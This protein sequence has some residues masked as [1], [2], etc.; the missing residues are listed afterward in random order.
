[1]RPPRRGR[2]TGRGRGEA[3]RGLYEKIYIPGRKNPL[4][5]SRFPDIL[6]LLQRLRDETHRF[7]ISYY[8]SLHRADLVS[9][10][11]DTI[12][13][14]GAKRRQLLLQHF[15]SIDSLRSAD[16][17]AIQNEVFA[18]GNAQ[19]YANLRDWFQALY[20]VL[21]GQDQGPR[22][23]SFVALYGI[24]RTRKLI[25]QA[26]ACKVS[27]TQNACCGLHLPLPS[28]TP[29]P[30]TRSSSRRAWRRLARAEEM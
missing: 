7:A 21:L 13:G 6:H 25:A 27:S 26:L 1:L 14:V 29:V 11:L 10:V 28:V 2:T 5:L 20:Q 22:F 9:S 18:V 15:P 4:F 23:G 16:A 3:G 24:G 12:P 17:E 8:Q 30:L 19:G